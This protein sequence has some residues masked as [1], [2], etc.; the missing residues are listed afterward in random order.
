MLGI[1]KIEIH[2]QKMKSPS[3]FLSTPVKSNL[4]P[5]ANYNFDGLLI[6][7]YDIYK[8][9]LH[10]SS[11]L[12]NRIHEF[13][14]FNNLVLVDS[15][16]YLFMNLKKLKVTVK[17]I[18]NVQ[19][20]IDGDIGV[21]LDFPLHTSL[22]KEQRETRINISL[23]NIRKLYEIYDNGIEIMPVIH[24]FSKDEIEYF[25]R[26]LEEI[27]DFNIIGIGSLVNFTR[28]AV[29]GKFEQAL[30]IIKIVREML[31][32]VYI[33]AFGISSILAMNLAFYMGANS[34]DAATW[35]RVASRG[36]IH[37]S[38]S[39][40]KFPKKLKE[41]SSFA[42]ELNPDEFHCECPVCKE[43]TFKELGESW[44]LRALHNAYTFQV[45]INKIRKLMRRGN[46]YYQRYLDEIT[47]KSPIYS[48]LFEK[49]NSFN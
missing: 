5:W 10:N 21:T 25:V 48:R 38:G 19:K 41:D 49:I 1:N 30:K 46:G 11:I 23:N 18:Y 22:S 24:G 32:K 31:P 34:V 47:Q 12:K 2:G 8:S 40:P 39:T 44:E 36:L 43:H 33:H 15:G 16:G 29:F 28:Y 4:K 20:E 9:K 17:E 45:E 14:E 37:I 42:K 27:A 7:A 26:N 3:L 13:L 35:R 6:N